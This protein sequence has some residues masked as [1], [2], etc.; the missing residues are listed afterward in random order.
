MVQKQLCSVIVVN[1]PRLAVAPTIVHYGGCL[2]SEPLSLVELEGLLY[3][4]FHIA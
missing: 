4:L 1:N 2:L 3:L